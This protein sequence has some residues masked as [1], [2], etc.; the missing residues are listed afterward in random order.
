[1]KKL[2]LLI[3][4]DLKIDETISLYNVYI[5]YFCNKRLNIFLTLPPNI[6]HNFFCHNYIIVSQ[7]S[8]LY[9]N[10]FIYYNSNDCIIAFYYYI[11]RCILY[12]YTYVIVVVVVVVLRSVHII[13]Q[14][15][16]QL[17]AYRTKGIYISTKMIGQLLKALTQPTRRCGCWLLGNR[18][19][20]RSF[21]R[22]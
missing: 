19:N 6:V 14:Q 18:L 4:N 5:I 2:I 20:D 17:P 3:F 7:Y 16:Q 8:L 21:N 11:R 15:W 13:I 10:Y 9:F 12:R 22:L 1:M